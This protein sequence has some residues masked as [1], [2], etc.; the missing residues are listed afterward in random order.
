MISTKLLISQAHGKEFR[1]EYPFQE[2]EGKN[3]RLLHTISV[4][5]QLTSDVVPPTKIRDL[6]TSV[7]QV[8]GIIL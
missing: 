1:R 3:C 6:F 8:S 5:H 2:N 4:N 7:L